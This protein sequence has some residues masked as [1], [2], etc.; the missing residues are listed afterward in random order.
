MIKSI[1]T[2]E[3]LLLPIKLSFV[4]RDWPIIK[5]VSREYSYSNSIKSS[6]KTSRLEL[7]ISPSEEKKRK[8]EEFCP[9]F[10]FD[11]DDI[12]Y[13][14]LVSKICSFEMRH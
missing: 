11:R 6:V 5:R 2:V 14:F 10:T 1:A 9:F 13:I 8:E 12:K 4:Y 3:K 7:D